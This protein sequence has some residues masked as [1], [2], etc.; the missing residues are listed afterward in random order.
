MGWNLFRRQ[1]VIA[2]FC[3]LLLCVPAYTGPLAVSPDRAIRSIEADCENNAF[4][5]IQGHAGLPVYSIAVDEHPLLLRYIERYTTPQGLRWIASA[6]ERG[7]LYRDYIVS[8]IEHFHAPMEILFL[9]VIESEYRIR[10]ISRSGALGLWQFMT[11]SISPY[12]LRIDQWRDERRDFWLST[13]A[14]IQKLQYNYRV[15]DDWLLALAAYNCGVTRL[16]NIIRRTG[17][18]DFWELAEGG[19][20]PRETAGYVPKFL[21]VSLVCANPGRYGLELDWEPPVQWERIHLDQ[22]VDLR[23]LAQEAGVPHS[24]LSLSNGELHYSLTPPMVSDYYLKV[25]SI[26]A[27]AVRTTLQSNRFR[28]M[29]FYLYTVQ[30]GDTL[31]ALANHYGTSVSMIRRYNT[32]VTPRA[33][34]LGQRIVI[35]A[36]REVEP[37][38]AELVE[39][40]RDFTDEYIVKPGDTLW[41]ISREYGTSVEAIARQNSLGVN[42]IIREGMRLQVP[43]RVSEDS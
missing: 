36:L 41:S 29:R 38:R 23:I 4:G 32:G 13:D 42:S 25:P 35:P 2:L 5:T 17:I 19:H 18:R 15:F 10:A 33:L 9:P 37:Y 20:L 16:N 11:N 3:F 31:Y 39:E 7:D 21:A 22:A 1:T 34:Q 6:L 40:I 43:S 12:G 28:L 24:V 26:Y 30:S 14:S 8:R 27:D